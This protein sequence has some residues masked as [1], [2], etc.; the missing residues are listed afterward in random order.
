MKKTVKCLKKQIV[1]VLVVVFNLKIKQILMNLIVNR[2]DKCLCCMDLLIKYFISK[3]KFVISD[4]SLLMWFTIGSALNS[5]S[6]HLDLITFYSTLLFQFW[7]NSIQLSI[8]Y[9]YSI[10]FCIGVFCKMLFYQWQRIS[11]SLL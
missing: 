6:Q 10:S 3:K 5:Y 7:D 8:V 2:Q 4:I 11:N 1:M 9:T